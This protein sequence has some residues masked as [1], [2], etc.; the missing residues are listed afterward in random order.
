MPV[1]CRCISLARTIMVVAKS[2]AMTLLFACFE[3]CE[4]VAR[5]RTD[6]MIRTN[7]VAAYMLCADACDLRTPKQY[8]K[9]RT[10]NCRRKRI[11]K[12]VAS[13]EMRTADP[14]APRP[15]SKQGG[16]NLWHIVLLLQGLRLFVFLCAAEPQ[17][18]FCWLALHTKWQTRPCLRATRYRC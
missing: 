8:K 2:G 7:Y 16:A 9:L 11:A 1:Y 6:C 13:N 3:T 12:S 18:L 4:V 5:N 10:S 17:P 14:S 15:A